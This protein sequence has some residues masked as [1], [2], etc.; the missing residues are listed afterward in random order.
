MKDGSLIIDGYKIQ[1]SEVD[2]TYGSPKGVIYK[3]EKSLSVTA[4]AN[5]MSYC[6]SYLGITVSIV[7]VASSVKDVLA[8]L[9]PKTENLGCEYTTYT[10]L[11]RYYFA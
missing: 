5:A 10:I 9:N 3:S 7:S 1:I 11:R 2:S 6:H 4:L 8:A